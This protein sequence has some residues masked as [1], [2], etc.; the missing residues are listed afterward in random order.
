MRIFILSRGYPSKRE[1]QRGCFEKDQAEALVRMGH[2]VAMLSVDRRFRLFWRHIGIT[3]K[4]G[5][6]VTSYDSFIVP[7]KL[8]DLFGK[9]FSQYT[10]NKQLDLIYQAAVKDYGK[11][12]LLYSHYLYNSYYALYLK[13]KYSIPLVGIEHWSE[14]AKENLSPRIDFWGHRTY[15]NLDLL[16]TVSPFLQKKIKEKFGVD[17]TV[18]YNMVGKEFL[19]NP[20]KQTSK[21]KR[22][23]FVG[24]LLPIKRVDL[25]I[26]AFAKSGIPQEDWLLY[27]VGDGEQRKFLED[28]SERLG[29]KQNILF[30]GKKK[31]EEIAE[32]YQKSDVM[33]L[34]SDIE[35]FSVV[36]IEGLA[37]GLPVI[38][39]K[40]GGP[41]SFINKESGLLCQTNDVVAFAR[42]LKQMQETSKQYDRQKIADDCQAQFSSQVIAQ[43]LTELFEQVLTK[44]K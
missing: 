29:L 10:R 3:K 36:C 25:I 14:L 34:A 2:E 1:P 5:N 30:L 16:I 19:Y 40:C 11:P 31:K 27:I 23:I 26:E 18:V 7:G 33:L 13:K 15:S 20:S 39:T 22:Y 38:A 28:L 35:T 9:R 12:D 42:A 44:E 4:Q 37:C 32:L 24:S 17:S 43:Q 21:Q 6:G 41:E 8:I